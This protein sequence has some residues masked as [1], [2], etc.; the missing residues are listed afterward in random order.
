MAGAFVLGDLSPDQITRRM[1]AVGNGPRD[2]EIFSLCEICVWRCGLRAKVRDGRVRKLEGNPAHPHS[3]GLLCPRGQAGIMAAYDPDRLQFPL[4]RAGERGSGLFRRATWEEALDYVAAKML[5]I[6]AESGPEAMIFSTTHN[7]AQI[8]FENLLRAFGSPNYGTQRSL[9]FN[10]MIT[11]HLLTY[12]IEEPARDYCNSK[13]IIYAGRNLMETISNSE[14][15]D[16]VCAL[17]HGVKVVLLDP[18]YTVTAS[19]AT[20]WHPIRPGTDLAFFLALLNV[21]VG[22]RRYD[23]LFVERYTV[24]FEELEQEVGQYTPEWAAP[25]TDIDAGDIRRIAREFSDVRPHCFAHPNWRT[26][27]FL[28]SFQAE[29]AIATLN[30][31]MGH[32]NKPGGCFAMGGEDALKLGQVPQ[33]SYPRVTAARLDGVPWKYPLVPLKLGVFQELR[34]NII[35]GE[36][37]QARG[38][39]VYRQNP[40][41]SLPERKK[42]L[43]ALSKL[44]LLATVDISLNDT[45]WF[46]DVVLPEASYLE[47]YDPLSTIENQAFIRQPVIEP[48]GESKS[49]LWIFKQ[50]G[51]RLGLDDFFA[52]QDEEDYLRAQLAPLKMSLEEM[53]AQ[54]SY[55]GPEEELPDELTWNTPSGKIEIASET[56]RN[57]GYPAVPAWQEPLRPPADQFYLISGKVAQHTQTTTQNNLWLHELYP[58]NVL[59]IHPTPA[60]ER[61]I[62]SG[63]KVRLTSDVGQIEIKAWVTEGIRPDC[64]FTTQ[65]FGKFS[66]GLRTAYGEG[67]S[68]SD[69]H[70]T[71]TDPI[72]GS[73]ALTQTC[74]TVEKVC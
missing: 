12:G 18:R 7:L 61:S 52:Y 15:Q 3:R 39:F 8:Q 54:G 55:T 11:A 46:S 59:W 48:V 67:V 47:R 14:T 30:A 36:P 51:E 32:W 10:A 72:S 44:D 21:I 37:Y 58:R 65:G 27:N 6:R 40:V 25:I 69:V 13:Y 42:T 66:K 16:L 5:Q 17:A 23:E 41:D 50:L 64:V 74:V 1:R 68:N 20:E 28:N 73:Q 9:C 57:A 38:W 60:A 19:K 26:S 56:L 4:I 31:L 53:K 45:A 24:G 63:D 34:D 62:H 49:G 70:V 35:N 2:R 22:E 33:P 43:A 71:F 29:R